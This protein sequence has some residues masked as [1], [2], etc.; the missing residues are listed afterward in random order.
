MPKAPKY[1]KVNGHTY[2]RAD[3]WSLSPEDKAVFERLMY[4]WLDGEGW[5]SLFE[6]D[7]SHWPTEHLVEK[8][9]GEFGA[10]LGSLAEENLPWEKYAEELKHAKKQKKGQ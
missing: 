3:V 5:R 1:I 8:M 10:Y 6:G 2:R 9:T 4:A 7:F